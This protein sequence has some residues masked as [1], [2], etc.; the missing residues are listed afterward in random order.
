M[1]ATSFYKYSGFS[2]LKRINYLEMTAQGDLK[3]DPIGEA[4]RLIAEMQVDT[5]KERMQVIIFADLSS[6]PNGP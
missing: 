5:E 3:K 6:H 4:E 1:I 2:A